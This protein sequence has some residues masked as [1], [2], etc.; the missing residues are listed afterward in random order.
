MSDLL[1][2]KIHKLKLEN[3]EE[4]INQF[5]KDYT[6]FIIKTISDLKGRYLDLHN[7]DELS[8]G[9]M[10]FNEAIKKYQPSKGSFLSFAKLVINSRIKTYWSKD[11]PYEYT[12]YEDIVTL[13][14]EALKDEIQLFERTLLKFGI[15]FEILIESSPKHLDTRKRAIEIGYKTSSVPEYVNHIYT[16]RRLPISLMA[17]AFDISV[18]IIKRSKIFI[19]S[20]VIVF[21]KKLKIIEEWLK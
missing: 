20:I 8:I 2:T 3:N 7:D 4:K 14:E 18:K 6:P 11:K 16:K 9:L 13:E 12:D 17:K 19:I 1:D 15:D 5:I 21:D 10:A